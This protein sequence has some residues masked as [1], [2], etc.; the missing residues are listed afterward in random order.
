MPRTIDSDYN[1]HLQGQA[2]TVTRCLKIKRT[3]DVIF[4]FTKLDVDLDIDLGDGDGSQTY[5]AGNS[6]R[7]SAVSHVAGLQPDNFSISGILSTAAIDPADLR[8]GLFNSAAYTLFEQNYEDLT[9]DPLIL[10]TGT[11][12]E[13]QISDNSFSVE[14]RPL[15]DAYNQRIGE[16]VAPI[17]RADLGD[18]RCKVRLVPPTWAALTA[19][20]VRPA[21]DA[22]LGSVVK[23]TTQNLRH[24]KCTTTGTSG[25]SEPA[26]NTTV[27]GT[28]NDGTVVWTTIKA[29]SQTGTV[30]AVV[31]R[32]NFTATGISIEA[33]WWN[34]GVLEWLTGDN[35]G[36]KSEV[37]DDSGTGVLKLFLPAAHLPVIGD[38]F[39]VK[40]G[41]D[42]LRDICRGKFD[43]IHNRRAEDYVPGADVALDYPDAS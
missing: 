39:F 17:C 11:L 43:N 37:K 4:A 9:Q 16:L 35:G 42:K 29:L 10:Q 15:T 18:A 25:A 26:W 20:T 33:D 8:A 19:Y 12:G 41:C 22:G 21:R 24:F 14:M 5:Q 6:T 7:L 38:T 2:T 32:A 23:P 28:T 40:V 1:T 34:Y 36:L 31:D 3:D 13:V 30:S 27:G